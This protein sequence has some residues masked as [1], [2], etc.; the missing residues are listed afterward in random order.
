MH[1]AIF[2]DAAAVAGDAALLAGRAALRATRCLADN[3]AFLARFAAAA[4]Q[5]SESAAGGRGWPRCAGVAPRRR[6]RCST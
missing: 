3:D 5:F 6:P 1:L 2:F 4:D